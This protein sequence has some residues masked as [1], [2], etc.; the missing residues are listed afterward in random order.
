MRLWTL[1]PKYLDTRG[2]VALWREALLA[3]AVLNGQTRGYIHHPQLIRFRAA[4]EPLDAIGSYLRGI[5]AEAT[6]RGYRFAETKII[7]TQTAE[8]LAASRGQ[9]DYEW[10]HLKKKL[11]DRD[12][13]RLAGFRIISRPA[14]HPLFHVAPGP[15]AEWEIIQPVRRRHGRPHP[16]G[17]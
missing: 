5:L 15:V 3:Q 12:P 17:R 10:S 9:V 11:R 16:V 6:R 8:T 14:V 4:H 7:S 1:H 13:S 2:L